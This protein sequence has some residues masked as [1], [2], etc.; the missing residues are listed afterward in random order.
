MIRATALLLALGAVTAIIACS[1][2]AVQPFCTNIPANGCPGGDG[3]ASTNCADTTCE[4]IYSRTADCQWVRV[5]SCPGFVAPHDAGHDAGTTDA[6]DAAPTLDV[7]RRDAGFVVPPGAAG[8]PGC[9]DLQGSDCPLAEA[10]AGCASTGCGSLFVCANG[11]WNLW[12]VCGDAG[13]IV[14]LSP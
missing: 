12:G 5:A 2:S 7:A 1:T 10:L 13:T 6:A 3:D 11:G 14:P 8:G 9:A 4:A